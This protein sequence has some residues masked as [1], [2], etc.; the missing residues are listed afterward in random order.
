MEMA[1]ALTLLLALFLFTAESL[2]F[3][4]RRLAA[5]RHWAEFSEYRRA[6]VSFLRNNPHAPQ[7][8]WLR[9]ENDGLPRI[10]NAGAPSLP[11][12]EWERMDDGL[13]RCDLFIGQRSRS[14]LVAPFPSP[15]LPCEKSG[16]DAF[17]P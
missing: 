16:G 10:C 17:S 9:R 2:G 7:I 11:R 13:L 15:L 1:L 5:C 12:V 6:I 3:Q 4:R 14:F 8:F